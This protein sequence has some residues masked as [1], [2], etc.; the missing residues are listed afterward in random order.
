[1]HQQRQ[2]PAHPAEAPV[3]TS[4][5]TDAMPSTRWWTPMATQA[6]PIAHGSDLRA[7]A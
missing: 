4:P 5:G 3:A 1:M 6:T 2:C 7:F